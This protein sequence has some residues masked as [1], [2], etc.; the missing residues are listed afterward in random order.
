MLGLENRGWRRADSGAVGVSTEL[1]KALPGD[2]RATLPLAPGIALA[3][4]R[5]AP[6]QTLGPVTVVDSSGAEVALGALGAMT[7]SELVYDLETSS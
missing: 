5:E 7:F 2:L 3:K 1:V 4:V 6:E